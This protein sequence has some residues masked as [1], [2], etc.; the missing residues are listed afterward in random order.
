MKTA[1]W[2]GAFAIAFCTLILSC[3]NVSPEK[4]SGTNALQDTSMQ[5][6]LQENKKLVLALYQSLNDTNWSAAKMLVDK[7]F[8]H[9]FVKDTG[10]GVTSWNGFEEG[11]R[12]SQKAFPDWKLAPVNVVAEGDYVTVLVMGNGT[13]QGEFAGLPATNKKVAA[14]IM[15]LHQIK[16][17]K[18][19]ADWEIMNPNAF[20]GQLKK[21]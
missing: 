9:H 18:I 8:K 7:D 6:Q 20:L 15:V 11:Y 2:P 19:V 16:N 14:P 3:G 21:E 10:F 13:H 12:M 1:Y 5:R 17:G 4:T